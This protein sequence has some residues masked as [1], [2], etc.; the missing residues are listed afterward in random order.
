VV[1]IKKLLISQYD[2]IIEVE[3]FRGYKY[4]SSQDWLN[5]HEF[6]WV[7]LGIWDD[8]IIDLSL[9]PPHSSTPNC[10]NVVPKLTVILRQSSHFIL[11]WHELLTIAFSDKIDETNFKF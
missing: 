4:T 7:F 3:A 6:T 2:I 8:L 11:S 5:P 9:F 10:L 1:I